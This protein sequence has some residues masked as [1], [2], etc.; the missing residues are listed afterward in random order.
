MHRV[1]VYSRVF[2]CLLNMFLERRLVV[3]RD[4]IILP[5]TMPIPIKTSTIPLSRRTE[6]AVCRGCFFHE[7]R[8]MMV[9]QYLQ[10]HFLRL[11]HADVEVTSDLISD[12]I[13]EDF[14]HEVK[15]RDFDPFSGNSLAIVRCNAPRG[16]IPAIYVAF[17]TGETGCE[18]SEYD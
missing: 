2:V 13:I 12:H 17:P 14:K 3:L 16:R 8:L 15:L 18:L 9:T 5:P 7:D 1:S 10:A 4:S 11:H 6:Q